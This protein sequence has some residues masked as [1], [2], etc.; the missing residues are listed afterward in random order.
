MS[1]SLDRDLGAMGET[2][3]IHPPP[4]DGPSTPERS[5]AWAAAY[6]LLAGGALAITVALLVADLDRGPVG[7]LAMGLI[8]LLLGMGVHVFAAML[9]AAFLGL[10]KLAG[11][12]VVWVTAEQSPFRAVDGWELSVV[13][14][15]VFMGTALWRF[16][17][18]DGLFVVANKWLGRLP[19]GLAI[20][21][22]FSGAGLSAASGNTIGIS[23]ALG[24]IAIPQMMRANYKPSFAA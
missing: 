22:N 20:A 16:R 5:R 6:L 3:V 8:L 4:G 15:F 7:F 9:L 14:M 17:L 12:D 24:R 23:Y 13:P 19:G 10:W 1:A 2:M 18:T 21:T 11:P